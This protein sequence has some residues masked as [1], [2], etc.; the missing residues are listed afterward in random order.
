MPSESF[1]VVGGK[2]LKGSI[3]PQGAKN[4]TLQ[5]LCAVLLTDKKVTITN[6]PDII[7]VRRLIALLKGLGVEVV[8]KSADTYV[9]QAKDVDLDFFETPEFQK[10]AKKIRGS[11]MLLSLIHI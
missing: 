9:F 10:D 5:I 1:K 4:E 3:V 8:K 2:K 6:V 11:V 7:D